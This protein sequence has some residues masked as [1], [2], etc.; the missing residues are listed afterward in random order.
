M[1][2]V[3]SYD[4]DSRFTTS[5]LSR[6][7][8]VGIPVMTSL[9]TNIQLL[10]PVLSTSVPNAYTFNDTTSLLNTWLSSHVSNCLPPTWKSLLLIIRLLNL[11]DLAQQIETYLSETTDREEK[12]RRIKAEGE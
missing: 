9:N 8:G 12:T 3:T 5:A 2:A 6:L 10:R 11:D 1:H 4:P 7:E